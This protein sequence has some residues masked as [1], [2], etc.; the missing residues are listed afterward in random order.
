M[1][2]CGKSIHSA[3]V[4]RKAIF[5][6]SILSGLCPNRLK[7]SLYIAGS[8]LSFKE[9]FQREFN[10]QIGDLPVKYLGLPLITSRLS[11][12]DCKPLIDAILTRIKGWTVKVLSYARRLQLIQSV[13]SSI[14]AYWS[15]HLVL[16][17]QIIH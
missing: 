10:F 14:H 6:F 1:L 5:D 17:K 9:E 7:S 2:F 16:P 15:S 11:E 12:D 4:L 8:D 3:K 13:I